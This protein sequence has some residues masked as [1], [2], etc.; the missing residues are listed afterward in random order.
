MQSLKQEVTR[1]A[2]GNGFSGVVRV[3]GRGET[4]LEEAFGLAHRGYGLPNTVKT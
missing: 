2:Q 3:D 4:R 1:F